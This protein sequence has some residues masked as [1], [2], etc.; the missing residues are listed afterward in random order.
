MIQFKTRHYLL[1][2]VAICCTGLLG[3]AAEKQKGDKK[4]EADQP[5]VSSE[6]PEE[7]KEAM[8][9]L[10][11][12]LGESDKAISQVNEY[13]ATFMKQE[14]IKK[15]LHDPESILLKIRHQPFSVYMKWKESGQ[16][17]LFVEG[18]NDGKLLAK[19]TGLASLVGTVK[20][21]P[22]SDDAM[23]NSRYPITEAGIERLTERIKT[24]YSKLENPSE[25]LTCRYSEQKVDDKPLDVFEI[26]FKDKDESQDYQSSRLVFDQKSKILVS[27]ENFGW[28]R[29]QGKE[30][31]VVERYQFHEIN[32]TPG[33]TDTDFDSKNP[34]Y[35][36]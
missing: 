17:V 23:K 28:P 11:Q 36:F 19:P 27:V 1:S 4:V 14:A 5:S 13:T 20:I 2:A 3:F 21:D 8:T 9:R 29:K 7:T 24:Y 34:D 16:E 30:A 15:K 25:I 18:R 26:V 6:S 32:F 22:T 31:P 33:L 12:T 35:K 10:M